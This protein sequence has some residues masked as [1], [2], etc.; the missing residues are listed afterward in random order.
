MP[1]FKDRLKREKPPSDRK[2]FLCFDQGVSCDRAKALFGLCFLKSER[3]HKKNWKAPSPTAGTVVVL[4][5]TVPGQ[6]FGVL[7]KLARR[8]TPWMGAASI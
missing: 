6:K 5:L 1:D 7:E 2:N 8:P 3:T 4:S